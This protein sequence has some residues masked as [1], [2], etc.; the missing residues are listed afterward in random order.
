MP[1]LELR[2]LASVERD[3]LRI[4]AWQYTPQRPWR[5]PM[6]IVQR[7]D[8]QPEEIEQVRLVVLDEVDWT[9][10]QQ[11]L[12]AQL[13]ALFGGEERP[14]SD[15]ASLVPLREE[16]QKKKAAFAFVAP[17]GIGPTAWTKDPKKETHLRRRFY[18][19]GQTLDGMR[20]WDI[21]RAL[22]AVRAAGYSQPPQ[23]AAA[24]T[25]AGNALYA[26]LFEDSVRDVALRW[27]PASHSAGPIYLNVLRFLDV[28]QALAMASA[29]AKVHLLTASAPPWSWAVKAP[30]IPGGHGALGIDVRAENEETPE[31]QLLQW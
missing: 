25:M 9:T 29:R 23:L 28:P 16:L 20:V 13:P 12:S 7:A 19:I 8:L 22:A 2:E 11:M 3:G 31:K 18:L 5:L 15:A 24:R 27:L 14:K 10:L 17:R 21:R 30:G 4:K 6:Y 1:D 26:S